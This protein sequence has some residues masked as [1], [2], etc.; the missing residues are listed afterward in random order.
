MCNRAQQISRNENCTCIFL[1][2]SHVLCVWI[3]LYMHPCLLLQEEQRPVATP[4][5]GNEAVVEGSGPG[6]KT[7]ELVEQSNQNRKAENNKEVDGSKQ[8]ENSDPATVATPAPPASL[9]TAATP[10]VTK[11]RPK[12]V[13]SRQDCFAL[14]PAT[15]G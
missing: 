4:A 1:D 7:T 13:L 9:P 14:K 2:I 11:P 6:A 10:A 15:H 12:H 5:R 8:N 3:L